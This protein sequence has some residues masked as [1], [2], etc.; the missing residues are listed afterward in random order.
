[1]KQETELTFY[2]KIGNW[3]GFE[4]ALSMEVQQ[5]HSFFFNQDDE[6]KKSQM[7]VRSTVKDGV[8]VYEQTIKLPVFNSDTQTFGNQEFSVEITEEFFHAWIKATQVYGIHKL[9]YIFLSKNVELDIGNG[10]VITLPEIKYEVDVFLNKNGDKSKWCKI[11]IE[12]DHILD[13]LKE[14]HKDI[15]KFDVKVKI[16]SLPIQLENVFSAKTD[17][18]EEK[19]AIAHFWN[20][21]QIVPEDKDE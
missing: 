18:E 1:M 9:R 4:Q 11:D 5:Q 8:A 16:S 6:K 13:Y 21:F 2:G 15:S 19:K 20:T 14:Q 10:E 12:M 17:N 3:S 7:R